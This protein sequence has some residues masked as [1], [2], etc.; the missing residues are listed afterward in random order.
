M[1]DVNKCDH[2]ADAVY[3]SQANMY[4]VDVHLRVSSQKSYSREV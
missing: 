4:T 2:K 3:S 1:C